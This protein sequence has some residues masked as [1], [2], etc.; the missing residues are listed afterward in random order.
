MAVTLDPARAALALT[1][2]LGAALAECLC[3]PV[4]EV[5]AS[6]TP[7]RTGLTELA[8]QVEETLFRRLYGLLGARMCCAAPDGRLIRIRTE[9]LP[10]LADLCMG[11]LFASLQV[12][13]ANDA[14]LRDYAMQTGSL[15]ALQLL[16]GPYAAFRADGEIALM[17]RILQERVPDGVPV[18]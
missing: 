6:Y 13:Q 11:V 3:G 9:E 1:P 4:T 10:E 16:C 7:R 5:L 14:M 15:A 8:S 18:R 17:R 2:R 12:T